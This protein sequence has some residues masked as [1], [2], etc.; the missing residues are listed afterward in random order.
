MKGYLGQMFENKL[1]RRALY[2]AAVASDLITLHMP[3]AITD[4][5]RK[6]ANVQVTLD[7]GGV[8]TAQLLIVAEGRNSQTR[9]EAGI[10]TAQWQYNHSALVGAIYHEKPHNN[11]AYEIFYPSG[12]FAVLPMLDDAAGKHRSAIVWSQSRADA[13]AY[14]KLS[15]VRFYRRAG[16]G[17]GQYAGQSGNGRT[18]FELSARLSP[19]HQN[20]IGAFGVGWR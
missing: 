17:N 15:E 4:K 1:L 7:N 9:K 10:K 20:H 3:V 8:L 19:Y 5:S 16:K 2:Q 12:P 14:L 6:A 18:A 11:I 13:P